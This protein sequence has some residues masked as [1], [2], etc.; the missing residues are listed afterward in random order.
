MKRFYNLYITALF[1]VLVSFQALSQVHS[2]VNLYT[3]NMFAFNPAYA[4][5]GEKLKAVVQ[6]T[7]VLGDNSNN[8]SISRFNVFGK[9]KEQFGMGARV[10]LIN[11]QEFNSLMADIAS[12]YKIQIDENQS[13]QAGLSFGVFSNRANARRFMLNEFANSEDPILT[14]PT[15][16]TMELTIGAGFNYQ[17]KNAQLSVSLP[18]MT[19]GTG[20]LFNQYQVVASYNFDSLSSSIGIK[21]LVTVNKLPYSPTYVDVNVKA[22]WNNKAWIQP[23]VRTTGALMTALGVKI[24]E[25]NIGYAFGIPYKKDG[26]YNRSL[27]EVMLSF[28][29]K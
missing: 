23:G 26:L 27:H 3:H 1:A 13:V 17:F 20:G 10:M 14:S 11:Q 2:G 18:T 25:L 28:D 7:R 9:V 22:T 4:T 12:S 5:S 29:F 24:K 6:S 15:N 16:N 8:L 21:P 19:T